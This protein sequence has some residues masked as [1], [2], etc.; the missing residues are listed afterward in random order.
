[1]DINRQSDDP[2]ARV[3][4]MTANKTVNML[5]KKVPVSGPME[6]Q[7]SSYGFCCKELMVS[8]PEF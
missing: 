6:G 7:F 3:R 5:V 1:L 8:V 4:F 2:A